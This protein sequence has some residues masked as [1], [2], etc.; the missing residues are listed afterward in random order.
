MRAKAV[1]K[2][3]CCQKIINKLICKSDSNNKTNT[4]SMQ[5]RRDVKLSRRDKYKKTTT[6]RPDSFYEKFDFNNRGLSKFNLKM[7]WDNLKA[8]FNPNNN[9][10]A[11]M[12]SVS[13]FAFID[14]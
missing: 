2:Q 10:V 4:D 8:G 12:S 1:P 6:V 14:K 13:I 7:F 9:T 3:T 5:E 11:N